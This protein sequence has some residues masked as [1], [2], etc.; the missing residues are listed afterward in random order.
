[1]KRFFLT[2]IFLALSMTA[3]AQAPKNC[4]IRVY[5]SATNMMPPDASKEPLGTATIQ[6]VLDEINADPDIC[7]VDSESASTESVFVLTV[8]SA[9][10]VDMMAFFMTPDRQHYRGTLAGDDTPTEAKDW[11]MYRIRHFQ[12]GW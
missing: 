10:K 6:G 3:F 5:F 8:E 7:R 1:M 11:L 2:L 12:N 9:G 4:S